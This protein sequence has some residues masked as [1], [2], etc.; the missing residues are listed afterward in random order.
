MPDYILDDQIGFILRQAY[1]KH[2]VLFLERFGDEL[3][4]T[5]WAAIAKLNEV[6]ACSQ[7][8]LG[9]LTA[10]DAATIKGVVDRLTRRG[11]IAASPSPT[12]RRRVLITLTPAGRKAY[13]RGVALAHKVSF[14]TLARLKP[15]D[16]T[17]L[18]RLLKQLG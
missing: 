1:Q 3:T 9:R 7:N 2:A 17:V 13:E 10:M 8:L 12:D 6:G 5:Q 18:L 15:R 16:R 4:P 14:D 11:L